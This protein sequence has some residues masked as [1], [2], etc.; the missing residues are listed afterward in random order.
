MV[1]V[2]D[3]GGG[4]VCWVVL[5]SGELKKRSHYDLVNENKLYT[6]K[7]KNAL[8]LYEKMGR[9]AGSRTRCGWRG[10]CAKAERCGTQLYFE[11]IT[12]KPNRGRK[13]V[14]SATAGSKF[15]EIG[16]AEAINGK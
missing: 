7:A 13:M 9:M 6:R 16:G 15:I 5:G 1:A 10:F 4:R 3:D 14:D 11:T 2:G 8:R 12:M